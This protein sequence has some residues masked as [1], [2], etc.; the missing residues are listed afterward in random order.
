M[1][2]TIVSVKLQWYTD[3]IAFVVPFC[4]EYRSYSNC[5]E[6]TKWIIVSLF[7]Y[8]VDDYYLHSYTIH[9]PL[10]T[11]KYYEKSSKVPKTRAERTQKILL[12][13][14]NSNL[15]PDGE[16]FKAHLMEEMNQNTVIL[17]RYHRHIRTRYK[18]RI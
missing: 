11:S 17:Y 2:W 5:Y 3:A 6:I 14:I 16:P 1:L 7:V 4:F 18:A 12:A 15:C 9:N 13:G 8:Y 10:I